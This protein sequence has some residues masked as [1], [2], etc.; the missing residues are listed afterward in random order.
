MTNFVFFSPVPLIFF[1]IIVILIKLVLGW[2]AVSL[3]N[4]WTLYLWNK[5][6]LLVTE[7]DLFASL[8]LVNQAAWMI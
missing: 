3:F 5:Y 7:F 2:S 6:F 1:N 8:V 4:E